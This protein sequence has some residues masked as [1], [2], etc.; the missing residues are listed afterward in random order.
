MM[1]DKIVQS[2][3]ATLNLQLTV[4]Q[5]GYLIPQ[6]TKSLEAYDYYLRAFEYVLT[7]SPDGFIKARKMAE[8]AIELD[9]L[10]ADA[11]TLMG[12]F[13]F[14]GYVWQWEQDPGV[15][16]RAAKLAEKAVALD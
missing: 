9:P 11:Y 12:F 6:R 10:Y 3:V 7:P 1:Q 15:L 2:L 13:Y 8:K 4:L 5:R 16:D 14:V